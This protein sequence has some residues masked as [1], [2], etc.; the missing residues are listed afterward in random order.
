MPRPTIQQLSIGGEVR[1]LEEW[2][3]RSGINIQTFRTRLRR[4]W[5]AIDALATPPKQAA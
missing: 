4:G 2:S 1:S 3:T 5:D